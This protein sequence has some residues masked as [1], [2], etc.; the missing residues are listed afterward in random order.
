MNNNKDS[1][2]N[3]ISPREYTTRNG[4]TRTF[5]T[6]VGVAFK[7]KDGDG[8]DLQLFYVPVP[9]RDNVIRICVRAPRADEGHDRGRGGPQV[10]RK[11]QR[12]GSQEAPS[13]GLPDGYAEG[14]TDDIPY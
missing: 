4:E 12:P 8:F 10:D 9:Q 2:Y 5:W 6:Q 11:R 1:L 13:A 3:V 7:S 14:G